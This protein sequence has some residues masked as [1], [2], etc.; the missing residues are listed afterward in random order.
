[1]LRVTTP[2]KVPWDHVKPSDCDVKYQCYAH[3]E[4]P[5]QVLGGRKKL[6]D[7]T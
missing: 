5:C 1:V 7:V 4:K 2:S 3:V 6:G